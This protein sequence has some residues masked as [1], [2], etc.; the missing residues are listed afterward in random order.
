[1]QAATV[2]FVWGLVVHLIADWL[3]Q[4]EWMAIHKIDWRHPA[5]WIHSGIHTAV[6]LLVFTWPVALLIGITHLLIDTRQPLVWW[7]RIVKQMPSAPN[8]Q[9]VEIWVD[10]VMHLTVLAVAALVVGRLL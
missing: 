3:L 5:A 7:L 10:Q 8:Q 1:M 2:L 6:L 9:V 4:N